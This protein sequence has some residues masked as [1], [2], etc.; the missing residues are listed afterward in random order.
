MNLRSKWETN[1]P[2]MRDPR[3][4][5]DGGQEL[6]GMQNMYEGCSIE[7]IAICCDRYKITYY[8]MNVRYKLFENNYNPKNNRH[9]KP[10][11]FLSGNVSKT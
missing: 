5:D 8:V 2:Q 3:A 6:L 7:Q 4:K 10:L 11:V 1:N 9:R